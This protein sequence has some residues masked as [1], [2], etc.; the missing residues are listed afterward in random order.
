MLALTLCC[1]ATLILF[2]G[3]ALAA[4]MDLQ[5]PRPRWVSVEFEVS[6]PTRPYQLRTV[7]SERVRAWLEPAEEFGQVRITV[8]AGAVERRLLPE[9]NPKQGSFSNFVWIFDGVTGDVLSASLT[10]TLFRRL[11]WGITRADVEAKIVAEMSTAGVAGFKPPVRVLGN[12][13]HRFCD[14]AGS[15]RCTVIEGSRYDSETGYV[16]AV[17][18][19]KVGSSAVKVRVFSP[20]GEAV[21]SELEAPEAARVAAK[22]E[23]F[24]VPEPTPDAMVRVIDVA[25]S[26]PQMN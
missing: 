10:G 12:L 8:D 18:N 17:G 9:Q 22:S 7:Y 14:D 6:P 15:S 19:M 23:S 24:G 16:N 11:D 13:F 1:L 3:S 5:D 2:S 21:F 26:P 25:A 20:L 4:P